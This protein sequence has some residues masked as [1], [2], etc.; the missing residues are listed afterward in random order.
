MV[1]VLVALL[2]AKVRAVV[3][4]VHGHAFVR[5]V[6]FPGA[7][8]Q[9]SDR[10]DEERSPRRSP[11]RIS[12]LPLIGSGLGEARP[13]VSPP[14]VHVVGPLHRPAVLVE[15]QLL[16]LPPQLLAL[17]HDTL[18]LASPLVLDAEPLPLQE[19]PL[20]AVLVQA[21]LLHLGNPKE[22]SGCQHRSFL[23]LMLQKGDF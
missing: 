9:H 12:P 5:P 14:A 13:R 17:P 21:L 15:A 22:R 16:L 2:P 6:V 20:H 18:L 8:T 4:V 23:P 19:L 10:R 1:E 7:Q 3:A 11:L